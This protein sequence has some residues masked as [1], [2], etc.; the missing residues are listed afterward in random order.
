M[1]EHLFSRFQTAIFNVGFCMRKV[2]NVLI[3]H[4]HEI[5]IAIRVVW[6]NLAGK[7]LF[8]FPTCGEEKV[9]MITNQPNLN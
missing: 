5:I 2:E 9:E 7:E 3:K 6:P 8:I 4:I 1:V